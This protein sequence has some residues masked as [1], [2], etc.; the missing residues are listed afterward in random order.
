MHTISHLTTVVLLHYQ[1]MPENIYKE[2]QHFNEVEITY[3][4]NGIQNAKY[5][6]LLSQST[7]SH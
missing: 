2:Q 5:L 3:N 7:C 1:R 4:N 6:Q